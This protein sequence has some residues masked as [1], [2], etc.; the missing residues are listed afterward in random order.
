MKIALLSDIHSNKYALKNALE[1]LKE[2]NI[3]KYFFLGDMFGYYPWANET[4]QLLSELRLSR[5]TDCIFLLGN[6]DLLVREIDKIPSPLPEYYPVILQN[7][8]EL[9]VEAINWLNSLSPSEETEILD[10]HLKLFHGTPSDPINGRFYPDDKNQYDWFPKQ[11]EIIIMAHTHYPLAFQCATGGWI[12][13][14]GSVGQPRKKNTKPNVVILDV[15]TLN[16]E[17]VTFSF[18]VEQVIQE[19]QNINWYP[20]A[21]EVLLRGV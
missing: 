7:R 21:V 19:L 16:I 9:P 2:K 3:D 17:F 8:S 20:R 18:D 14:T 12:I 11:N 10:Y 13:N 15:P 6:H 5:P 4:Y 1:A